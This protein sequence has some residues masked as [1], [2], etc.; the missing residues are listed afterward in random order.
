MLWEQILLI[1]F[2]KNSKLTSHNFLLDV[3]ILVNHSWWN[4][5]ILCIIFFF[6]TKKN[7]VIIKFFFFFMLYSTFL[8]KIKFHYLSKFLFLGYNNIHPFLLYSFLVGSL[9]LLL[10]IRDKVFFFKNSH[11]FFVGLAALFLGGL[12]GLGN[13]SWGYFWVNDSI[14]IILVCSLLNF[15]TIIHLKNKQFCRLN[16]LAATLI[17]FSMYLLRSG[18]V[19]SRHNF[20]S[21]KKTVNLLKF[22]LLLHTNVISSLWLY[23]IFLLYYIFVFLL[24]FLFLFF[25]NFKIFPKSLVFIIHLLIAL[26]LLTWLKYRAN[27]LTSWSLFNVQ[28]FYN[29][30]S[31]NNINF[32]NFIKVKKLFINQ[33]YSG[34]YAHITKIFFFYKVYTT[35]LVA[36]TIFVSTSFYF[37]I[38]NTKIY[39]G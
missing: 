6:L 23:Y 26:C 24:M 8:K 1:H 3:S 17:V 25:S 33:H 19:F 27:N 11:V 20:F 36:L 12:W 4:Y 2:L 10:Y 29:F 5:G 28:F 35:Y 9:V 7:N 22:T 34:N 38:N 21:I 14:E 39:V 18:F 37:L 31:S 15:L 16:I 32:S 30:F 13:S